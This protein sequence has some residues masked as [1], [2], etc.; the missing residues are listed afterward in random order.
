L[1]NEIH[2]LASNELARGIGGAERSQK[3][4]LYLDGWFLRITH[5]LGRKHQRNNLASHL[6]EYL[7]LNL[8]GMSCIQ[9]LK[10]FFKELLDALIKA[11][12]ERF[13]KGASKKQS[14]SPIKIR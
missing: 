5:C 3:G 13:S 9:A 8:K 2:G 4:G 14:V 6:T 7:R 11:G 1:S 10:I 12:I